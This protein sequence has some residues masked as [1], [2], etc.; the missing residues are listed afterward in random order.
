MKISNYAIRK[1]VTTLIVMGALLIF[2]FLSYRSMGLNLFPEVD[3]PVVTVTTLLPGASPE[4]IDEDVTD[5]LEEQLN[6]ISGVDYITSSSYDG[7]SSVIITFKLSKDP[8]V[9]L[10]DVRSKVNL[11]SPNLPD[12]AKKPVVR[13]VDIAATPIMFISVSGSIDYRKLAEYAD[14]TV[15]NELSSVTGVGNIQI[16]G[17]REPEIRIW[18][19]PSE[20]AAHHLTAVDVYNAVRN[21]HLKLPA[22]SIDKGKKE[23]SIN[24]ESEYSSARQMRRLVIKENNGQ[25][26]TLGDVARVENGT[27]DFTSVAHYNGHP[28]ISLGIRRQSGANTVKVANAVRARLQDIKKDAPEGVKLQISSDQSTFIKE[29]VA[30]VQLD[31]ILGVLLTAAVMFLFLRNFRV[32]LISILSIPVSLIGGFIIMNAW[33]FTLNNLTMLAMSLAVGLVIDDTIVVLENIYRH[34]EEGESAWEAAKKGTAE[35]GFAVIAST[36]TLIAVFLPVALMQGIIGQFFLEFGFTVAITVFISAFVSLTITPFL[37]SRWIKRSTKHGK[38]Y[39][40]LTDGLDW[41]DRKYVMLLE[42]AVSHRGPVIL[43]AV[44][45]F[46]GGIAILP[47]LGSDFLPPADRSQYQVSVELPTGTSIEATN[48]KL[49]AMEQVMFKFNEVNGVFSTAGSGRGGSVNK[50]V[51]Q[52]S[53]VQPNQR[54]YS[55]AVLMDSTRRVLTSK[56]PNAELSVEEVAAVGG[57][58][59]RNADVQIVLQGPTLDQLVKVEQKVLADIHKNKHFVGVATDLHINKPKVDVHINRAKAYNLGVNARSILMNIYTLFGGRDVAKYTQNGYRYKIR[60]KAD[61]SFRKNAANISRIQVRNDRGKLIKAANLLDIHKEKGPSVINRFNRLKSVTIFANVTGGISPGEGLSKIEGIIHKY[62]PE[63][64]QWKTSLMG[65]SRTMRKSF[66]YMVIAL[67]ISILIIYMVLAVQFESFIHP[68]TIMISLPLTIIG[69]SGALLI[70]NT[71]L[72]VFS[73]IGVIMLIGLVVKNAILLVDFAEQA[74][75]RGEQKVK[76]ML[77]AGERRLRPIL[78]TSVAVIFGLLPVALALNAGGGQRAP[79]GIAVIGGIITSTF[80]TLL[81]IPVVY[82]LLDDSKEWIK[83]KFQS[84]WK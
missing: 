59:Q 14:Q 30:G 43:I 27:E 11:A 68:F 44:V 49:Y 60:M 55:Q 69:V 12:A 79:L 36:S 65:T 58:G 66:G 78:M 35:V 54:K 10:E 83:G 74:R 64:G 38:I 82:L 52:V 22:G 7:R 1:P 37:S 17:L 63:N 80:L 76:A 51:I 5:A 23:F 21:N 9:A 29:S 47:L 20:L 75:K 28:T 16:S 45:V 34:I 19:N 42:W 32:T 72:N 6:T 57:G 25:K 41:L 33:G 4:V 53:L 48:R 71:T 3:I 2:G 39:H 15:K 84:L 46:A 61:P 56:F 18:L 26:T 81:V 50:G 31:I 24:V 77:N 8:N 70:T 13:K 40:T 67:L 62:T 73:F